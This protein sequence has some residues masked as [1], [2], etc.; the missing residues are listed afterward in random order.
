LR[1]KF[2]D[3]MAKKAEAYGVDMTGDFGEES[4]GT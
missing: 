1:K 4:E 3:E 2:E